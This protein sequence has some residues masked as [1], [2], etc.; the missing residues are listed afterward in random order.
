[1]RSSRGGFL[2]FGS[3]AQ[4]RRGRR[5]WGW[6]GWMLSWGGLFW[7]W[8][9][10]SKRGRE[11]GSWWEGWVGSWGGGGGR[12]VRENKGGLGGKAIGGEIQMTKPEERIKC[13]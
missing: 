9:W 7:F 1:M 10:R 12:G 3:R 8:R 13:E 11:G 6:S 4:K 5:A 2:V